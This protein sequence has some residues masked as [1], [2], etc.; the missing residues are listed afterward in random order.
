MP[1]IDSKNREQQVMSEAE[2]KRRGEEE[3][4]KVG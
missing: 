2:M 1:I 3:N 4:I